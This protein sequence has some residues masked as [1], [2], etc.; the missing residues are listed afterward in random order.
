MSKSTAKRGVGGHI[1]EGF[2]NIP[3]VYNVLYNA[4]KTTNVNG[5]S[6]GVVKTVKDNVKFVAK[7]PSKNRTLT[8]EQRTQATKQRVGI[9]GMGVASV[10]PVGPVA[11][12]ALGVKKSIADKKNAKAQLNAPQGGTKPTVGL[13]IK[14]KKK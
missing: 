1:K 9:V 7:G 4:P 3:K 14:D 5:P 11:A 13:K 8:P 2:K 12:F 10:T 6:K